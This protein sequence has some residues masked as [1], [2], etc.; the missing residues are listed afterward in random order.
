M[1]GMA[2]TLKKRNK[3]WPFCRA[4]AEKGCC[5]GAAAASLPSKDPARRSRGLGRPERLGLASAWIIDLLCFA[6][7]WLVG[8]SCFSFS[9]FFLVGWLCLGGWLVM[10]VG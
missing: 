7:F 6:S 4:S 8:L 10:L 5:C 2:Q 9:L 3:R 1:L